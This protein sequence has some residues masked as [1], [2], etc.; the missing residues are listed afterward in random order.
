MEKKDRNNLLR[1]GSVKLMLWDTGGVF[2]FF[3]Q[4]IL[5]DLV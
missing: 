4:E 5:S 3:S 2:V 1:Y